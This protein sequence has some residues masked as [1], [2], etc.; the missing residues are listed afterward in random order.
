MRV[1]RRTFFRLGMW[2]GAAGVLSAVGLSVIPG[3]RRQAALLASR[4]LHIHQ[5]PA[6]RLRTEFQ[7]LD[8]PEAVIDTYLKD[9]ASMIEPISRFSGLSDEFFTRFLLSTDF[10]QHN[11]D[12]ARTLAY[13]RLYGP[14]QS[15]CYNPCAAFD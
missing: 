14:Q 13:V 4:L 1:G 6:D 12:T 5:S 11:A 15:P 9:Y 3:S 7:Y 10:F 2:A 8:I